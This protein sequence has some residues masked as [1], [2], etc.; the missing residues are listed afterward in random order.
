MK[1]LIWVGTFVVI[2]ILNLVLALATGFSMGYGV[3]Y[4]L[5]FFVPK[6]LCKKYDEKRAEKE[7]V[8]KAPEMP[9]VYTSIHQLINEPDIEKLHYTTL[10]V[11]GCLSHDGRNYNVHDD[12][13]EY[14]GDYIQAIFDGTPPAI[15][16][17]KH[18]FKGTLMVENSQV[19]IQWAKQVF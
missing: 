7:A 5:M 2:T 9:T 15:D 14:N 16:N 19:S 13:P 18:R 3:L 10:F 11:E 4:L 8:Y 12:N 1:I 17:T 6:K